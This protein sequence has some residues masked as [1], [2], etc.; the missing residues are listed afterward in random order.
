MISFKPAT[1]LILSLASGT[2]CAQV[3]STL[4]IAKKDT[5]HVGGMNMDAVRTRTGNRV[6]KLPVNV[7][8][9]M[10]AKAEHV[11][12]DGSS[13]GLSFQMQRL[14]LFFSSSITE[15]IFF[16]SEIEFEEGA[17]EIGIEFASI[18]VEFT[19]E[20]NFRGG[21]VMNPIGA[22]NENHDGPRWEFNDRP[23]SA[24]QMLPA[25]WSNVGFGLY[26]RKPLGG[27]TVGYEAYL[28]NGFDGT[29]ISNAEGRTFLPAAKENAGRFG[30]SSNG[31]PLVTGRLAVQHGGTGELGVSYMGGVYNKF[32]DDGATLDERRRLDV[33][34]IDA[35]WSLWRT[36][37]TGEFAW[38]HVD[39][40]ETYSQQFGMKQR[41]GFLDIVRPIRKGRMLGFRDA[42]LNVAVRLEY[43][44]WNIARFQ[45][46]GGVIGD[47]VAAIVPAVSF[48]PTPSTI[49]RIN[50]IY[51]KQH[52]LLNNPASRTAG[53]QFGISSYF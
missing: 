10:E 45:E 46:T 28:T 42:T 30:E 5:T 21:V 44:D 52:D 7:G 6:A 22:F 17:E 33:F 2:L 51:R 47:D 26:G 9:Y 25:T 37:F 4:F 1:L 31:A 11:G 40:P 53:F 39:V 16:N 19:P 32:Q 18:D 12:T 15:R 8:G 50:Y 13:E 24:T 49:F 35:S 43:V 29:I 41:G 20:L 34:A 23:I 14:T 36:A 3:D 38:V 27:F 48:R